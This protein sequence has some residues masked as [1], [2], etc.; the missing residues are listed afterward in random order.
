MSSICGH[1]YSIARRLPES[2][3]RAVYIIALELLNGCDKKDSA[4]EQ[5]MME[6]ETIEIISRLPLY[7]LQ[8]VQNCAKHLLNAAQ[9]VAV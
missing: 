7:D 6:L 4:N 3:A 5:T 8:L 9:E 1:I 2:K